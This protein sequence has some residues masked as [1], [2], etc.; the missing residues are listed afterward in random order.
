MLCLIAV[1]SGICLRYVAQWLIYK[2]GP[3]RQTRSHPLIYLSTNRLRELP[4]NLANSSHNGKR[5]FGSWSWQLSDCTTVQKRT[6]DGGLTASFSLIVVSSTKQFGDCLI[7]NC[8][9]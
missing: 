2:D 1:V 5:S 8:C 7:P 4:W 9:G 3:R 6:E